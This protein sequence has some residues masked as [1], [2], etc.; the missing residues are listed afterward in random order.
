[1]ETLKDIADHEKNGDPGDAKI[2]VEKLM[3]IITVPVYPMYIFYMKNL[4]TIYDV[5]NK[6]FMII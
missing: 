2:S 6:L 3:R 4:R 1:M 5:I